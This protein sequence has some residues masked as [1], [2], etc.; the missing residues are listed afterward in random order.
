VQSAYVA[1]SQEAQ[2]RLSAMKAAGQDALFSS[3]L[4]PLTGSPYTVDAKGAH[5]SVED[6]GDRYP[7]VK[8]LAGSPLKI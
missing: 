3:V 2:F 1:D 6:V 7:F 5:T 4:D 8:A